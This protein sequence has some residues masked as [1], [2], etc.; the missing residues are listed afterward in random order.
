[1]AGGFS[2]AKE[3]QQEDEFLAGL[4][5]FELRITYFNGVCGGSLL[6]GPLYTE[7]FFCHHSFAVTAK[8]SRLAIDG[9]LVATSRQWCHIADASSGLPA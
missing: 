6:N 5:R 9:L 1:M 8:P 2:G 7:T 4:I 3:W